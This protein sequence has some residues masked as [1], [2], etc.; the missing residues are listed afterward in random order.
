MKNGTNVKKLVIIGLMG[1]LSGVLMLFKFPIPLMPPFMEFD[2]SGLVEIIGGFVLGPGAAV[3]I[4]LVKLLVKLALMGTSTMFTGEASNFLVSCAYVLPAAWI[5]R[6]HKSKKAGEAGMAIGSII[7]AMV[8]VATNL[9][10]I[11][12]FYVNLMGMTM[13]QI[14]SMCGAV[15]PL[16]KNIFTL[17]LFG[18][19]PFNLIKCGVN[20][21]VTVLVYKRVSRAVKGFM[22]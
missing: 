21:L 15:N 1:A 10:I 7:C 18:I 19:V 6:N 16:M 2:F 8:A 3:M 20:S 13:E 9:L 14:I 4:I 22:N 12:P 17:A 11:F 5:Y